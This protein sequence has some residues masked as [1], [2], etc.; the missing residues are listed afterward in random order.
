MEC[1]DCKEI[2]DEKELNQFWLDREFWY[3]YNTDLLKPCNKY[4]DKRNYSESQE[5]SRKI[6]DEIK[7]AFKYAYECPFSL[8]WADRI[9]KKIIDKHDHSPE[10]RIDDFVCLKHNSLHV[11]FQIKGITEGVVYATNV[12]NKQRIIKDLD[13]L[14]Y[15]NS[16]DWET[17][18]GGMRFTA[19]YFRNS[20][21]LR[22]YANKQLFSSSPV[23]DEKNIRDFCKYFCIPI[24]SFNNL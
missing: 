8:K 4:F 12:S 9:A 19:E 21:I 11:V 7:E 20:N 6:K 1:C 2:F 3:I 5:I 22:L 24:K 23:N 13:E 17:D 18:V 14:R 15:A 10:L 16:N